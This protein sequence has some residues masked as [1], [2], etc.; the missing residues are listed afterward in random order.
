MDTKLTG[1]IVLITG[2]ASGI[3]LASARAF[4]G[5]GSRLALIDIDEPGLRAARTELVAS[6]AQVAVAGADLSTRDGVEA[7]IDAVLAPFDGAVDVLVNNV[8]IGHVKSFDE[9]SDDDWQST[10]EVNFF[11]YVH[12]ARKVLPQL[13]E[14]GGAIVNNASA[15]AIQPDAKQAHYSASKAAVLV[16]TNTLAHAEAPRVRVNAV[17]AGPIWTPMWT[18]PGGAAETLAELHQLAPREAVDHEISLREI[19]LARIGEPEEVANVIVFLA[20][21]LASFVTGSVY[22]VDGGMVRALA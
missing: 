13:R 6:G 22:R 19:P 14:R 16:L 9:L 2:A 4:A 1:K 7:G 8:G 11:S 3:G 18:G 17:A 20:S 21:Q 10:L 12:A 5:E 15:L